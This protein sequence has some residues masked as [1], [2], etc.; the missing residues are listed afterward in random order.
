[1]KLY[2]GTN[3][4]FGAID[5]R[6]CKPNKDF[7]KDFYLTDP[8]RQAVQM[9]VRKCDLEQSG[10]PVV[11]VYEFDEQILGD[12][13]LKV[14]IFEQP[15]REWALF[16]LNNRTSRSKTPHGYD[17][18]IGPVAD[19]GVVYQLNQFKQYLITIDQLVEGLKYRKLNRQYFLA[20]IKPS[21]CYIEYDHY[22]ATTE[23]YH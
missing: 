19:D 10:T 23:I 3:V 16:I 15:S 20:H 7:G 22:T 13:G 9:A 11:Q 14:K 21:Q 18:V 17:I 2:H 1:M 4:D 5:F 8:K 6:K 12:E